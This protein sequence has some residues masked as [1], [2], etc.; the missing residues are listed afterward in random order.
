MI[1][2][3]S[4][5]GIGF[6]TLDDRSVQFKLSEGAARVNIRSIEG[7][8]TFEVDTSSA[9]VSLVRS[10]D[11]RVES[12]AATGATRI[13]VRSGMADLTG[14]AQSAVA[15]ANQMVLVGDKGELAETKLAPPLDAFDQFCDTRERRIERAASLEHVSRGVIGW[16]DLDEYGDWRPYPSYGPV[17]IPRQVGPGWAPYRFGHWVWIEPWGWTW[18]DD[19]RWGFAPFHYGR[20]IFLDAR[21]CWV[22]GPPRVGVIYAPALVIFVGGGRPGL[23]YHVGVGV[24]IGIGWFPLGPRE[25]YVPPYRTSRTYVTNVNISHTVINNRVNI[26]RTDLTRQTYMNRRV[27]GAITTVPEDAFISG[28]TISRVAAPM[29]GREAASA[30]ISGTAAPVA[31]TR[32][33]VTGD[34]GEGRRGPQ[35]PDS[36]TR[37]PVMV[38]QTPSLSQPSFEQRRADLEPDPGRPL[39][40]R[41]ADE[42]R[43]QR[44]PSPPEYRQIPETPRQADRPQPSWTPPPRVGESRQERR[45]DERVKED[46][47]RRQRTIDQEHQRQQPAPKAEQRRGAETRGSDSRTRRTRVRFAAIQLTVAVLLADSEIAW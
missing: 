18:V 17:W 26:H 47:N 40:S 21:W 15:R 34:P 20:W 41:R 32:R 31:P 24:G 10:G 19:A 35:P 45:T 36:V 29:D 3:D 44:A 28:R 38:R 11:Y 30:G 7:D 16:E 27:S 23:R 12:N 13:I 8:E 22:P 9:V 2:L 42:L 4:Q 33:S 5:T 46:A 43:Q 1:R 25:I 37:R 39:D 6:L 14:P